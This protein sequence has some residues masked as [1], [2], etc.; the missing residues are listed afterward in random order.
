MRKV[1]PPETL[2]CQSEHSRLFP[3]FVGRCEESSERC[4]FEFAVAYSTTTED[5]NPLDTEDLYD[6]SRTG[7]RVPAFAGCQMLA[8]RPVF[9]E[10]LFFG[11][12]QPLRPATRPLKTSARVTRGTAGS[13]PNCAPQALH[14]NG[15]PPMRTTHADLHS[16]QSGFAS[17]GGGKLCVIPRSGDSTRSNFGGSGSLKSPLAIPAR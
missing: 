1:N 6:E 7:S 9:V 11:H 15:A 14:R 17:A 10:P 8:A 2:F 13:V 3:G 16:G 12:C 5:A 4:Q